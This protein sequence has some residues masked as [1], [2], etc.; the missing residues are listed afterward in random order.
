[1]NVRRALALAHYSGLDR[2][3]GARF[4]M[5]KL[6]KPMESRR[7]NFD[8]VADAHAPSRASQLQPFVHAKCEGNTLDSDRAWRQT[9]CVKNDG[10]PGMRWLSDLVGREDRKAGAVS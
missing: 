6:L 9:S 10:E 2:A 5:G 4:I 8:P 7:S 3:A 1:M